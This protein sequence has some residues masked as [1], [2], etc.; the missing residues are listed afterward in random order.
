MTENRAII[1]HSPHGPQG[2]HLDLPASFVP[3]LLS[4]EPRQLQVE[5]SRPVVIVGRHSDADLQLAYPDVSRHHCRLAFENG[6][7]RICD[8]NSTNGV[9]LNKARIVEAA[10]Y[11]GDLLH[12]GSVRVLIKSATPPCILKGRESG[13]YDKLR[14]IVERLPAE[15][16]RRAS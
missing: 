10:L 4:I 11:A 2:P 3:L 15:S 6:Q 14:Q 13:K 5:V 8:L 12:I 16:V 1:A 9:Y 7:W